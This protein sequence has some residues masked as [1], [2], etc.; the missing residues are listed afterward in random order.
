VARARETR[1]VVA[2]DARDARFRDPRA[3][4]GTR[5]SRVQIPAPRLIAAAAVSLRRALSLSGPLGE[6]L[7]ETFWR[8]LRLVAEGTAG[9]FKLTKRG[10]SSASPAVFSRLPT[11]SAGAPIDGVFLGL[12]GGGVAFPYYNAL[13]I[14]PWAPRARSRRSS[15][16]LSAASSALLY[17]QGSLRRRLP[18]APPRCANPLLPKVQRQSG[19]QVGEESV[20]RRFRDARRLH[21]RAGVKQR[22]GAPARRSPYTDNELRRTRPSGENHRAP[23]LL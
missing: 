15:R 23:P 7:G 14:G 6:H 4:F 22:Q 12:L 9:P 11:S 10:L 3:G 8:G 18:L 2:D 16:K 17:P 5:R 1:E 19:L 13:K 20:R 21:H